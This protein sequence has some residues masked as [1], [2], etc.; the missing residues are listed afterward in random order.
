MND[1]GPG[2][3]RPPPLK[4]RTQLIY[5]SGAI[6]NAVKASG[7]QLFF[8]LFYNQVIGVP[9]QVV[10]TAMAVALI[11]D[12]LFDPL[13]GQISDNFRS[14]W[15]R[16]H[17]FMY[18]AALPMALAFVA[19]FNPPAGWQGAQMFAYMLICLLTLRFFDTFFELP[20]VSL[21]PE[22]T[23]DYKLR[24]RIF[25]MRSLFGTLAGALVQILA[26][27]V[28]LKANPDGS[29]GLLDRQGYL[30]YS[31]TAAGVIVF[32]VLA[33]SFGTHH[34]IPYL[35]APPRRKITFRGMAREVGA[36]LSNRA[37]I[38]VAVG[39]LLFYLAMAVR[40]GLDL[41]MKLYFWEFTQ[42]QLA[43]LA[44]GTLI[45]TV[46]GVFIA[47]VVAARIGKRNTAITFVIVSTLAGVGPVLLRLFGLMPAN[48]TD[49]LFTI[50]FIDT[51]FSSGV[52]ILTLVMITSMLADVVE[53]SEVKTGRRS[54]GLINSADQLFKK[55]VSGVGVFMSGTILA[56]VHF[57][58]NAR[59]GEVPEA[60]LHD[61]AWLYVPAVIV[62]YAAAAACLYFYR[63]DE[64][65]H[66]ANLRALGRAASPPVST[67]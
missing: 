16:R 13:V 20:S 59:R 53:D 63:I 61:L 15:G 26:Y 46:A 6:P 38:A 44:T 12:G 2:A 22:L 47:P 19:I 55:I 9:P 58:Q 51:I 1:Q 54:E 65:R 67:D 17:P 4:F 64:A 3:A 52:T 48:G 50:M 57:P 35:S 42:G 36:T 27:Q 31:L 34:R 43:L 37:F 39:G 49:L 30:G 28:F 8:L 62:L 29:G 24:T 33:A 23:Q 10:A 25:A 18:A 32:F 7:V 11:C 40:S 5:A 60:L 14:R 56:I 21:L 66:E 45:A 41:Y